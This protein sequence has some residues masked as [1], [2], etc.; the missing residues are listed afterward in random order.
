MK[1]FVWL[2]RINYTY[3][4]IKNLNIT[5]NENL[6]QEENMKLRQK[7]KNYKDN[8][9]QL[10]M[11]VKIIQKSGEIFSKYFFFPLNGLQKIFYYFIKIE[12]KKL[13]KA[14]EGKKV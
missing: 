11:L 2:S 14:V 10:I 8:Q 9:E 5:E 3:E 6:I 7:I 4:I 12:Q 13:K 1:G